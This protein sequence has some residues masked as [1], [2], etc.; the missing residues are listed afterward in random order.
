M[1]RLKKDNETNENVSRE[2]KMIMRE[3]KTEKSDKGEL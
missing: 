2:W 1:Y 3:M